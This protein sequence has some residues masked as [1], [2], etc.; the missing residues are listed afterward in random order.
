MAALV[1]ASP[2]EMCNCAGPN[3]TNGTYCINCKRPIAPTP[4]PA[5]P[6]YHVGVPM[7][8]SADNGVFAPP[9]N[10][11][12][13]C[14][15]DSGPCACGAWH[16][17]MPMDWA[18]AGKAGPLAETP[19]PTVCTS[20]LMYGPDCPTHFK[21]PPPIVQAPGDRDASVDAR[22]P[23][24]AKAM[25]AF[26]KRYADLHG[27][28]PAME[29]IDRLRADL[30]AANE[31]IADRK[32]HADKHAERQADVWRL[33]REVHALQ[34]NLEAAYAENGRLGSVVES[35]HKSDD[36][37]NEL[38]RLLTACKEMWTVDA[39]LLLTHIE[40]VGV[41]ATALAQ[42]QAKLGRAVTLLFEIYDWDC[43]P[44]G[45]AS[46]LSAILADADSKAAGEAWVGFVS[47]LSKYPAPWVMS[48]GGH[49]LR[50][51]NGH[52]IASY[53]PHGDGPW[54]AGEVMH[55]TINALAAVDARRGVK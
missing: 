35:L 47:L 37:R 21:A 10:A 25:A 45:A 30:A 54:V 5:G 53:D 33:E 20:C 8:A 55:D 31:E 19:A 4:S 49:C 23:A 51:A 24:V 42:M 17:I 39:K 50:S 36:Q 3:S 6:V 22:S 34:V 32:Y 38:Q 1:A 46:K 27:T 9:S 41:L 26:N 40:H 29:E 16:G 14:D 11:G 44:L 12:V 48:E 7:Q 13:A 52:Y 28:M 15:T 2:A 18:R 43:L